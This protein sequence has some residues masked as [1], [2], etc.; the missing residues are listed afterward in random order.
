MDGNMFIEAAECKR[1]EAT[2]GERQHA[3]Y[4]RLGCRAL[5]PNAAQLTVTRLR[6]TILRPFTD[7]R[8]A[9]RAELVHGAARLQQG[10]RGEAE[11]PTASCLPHLRWHADQRPSD[12][13]MCVPTPALRFHVGE[14]IRL[15]DPGRSRLLKYSLHLQWH[16]LAHL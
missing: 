10:V 12:D 16:G 9:R 14:V 11:P 6:S 7:V 13:S 8:P 5:P 3:P 2:G 15:L 1:S 4:R